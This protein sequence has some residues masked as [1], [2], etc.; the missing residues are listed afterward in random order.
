MT[1]KIL[2]MILAIV[3]VVSLFAGITLTASAAESV[4][5]S[6]IDGD[7][8]NQ[9]TWTFTDE[10]SGV[11]AVFATGTGSTKPRLDAN[12]IRFY[13]NNT[14]TVTAPAGSSITAI[15]FTMS[16]TSYNLSK[17][18]ADSG[19]I[20]STTHTWTGS[21]G[22]VVIT[23][24]AQVRMTG[25][26]VTYGSSGCAHTNVVEAAAVDP[27]CTT[28]GSTA[29]T[30]CADCGAIVTGC[31]VIAALGHSYSDVTT[32]PT[33][34][35]AGL[36]TSTC[37]VCG[38][39]QTTTI[40]ATGLHNFVDGFC[41]V[42]GAEDLDFSGTY[43]IAAIRSSGNYMY[44]SNDLGTASTLR[45]QA[46]DSTLT[47]LPEAITEANSAYTFVITRGED[48]TYTIT[49]A[50]GKYVS[51]T[52]GN[53][54][55]LADDP[56]YVN[57]AASATEGLVNISLVADSTRILALNNT[58]TNNY[59]AFYAGTQVKDL[60]LVP[61]E[62]EVHTHEYTAVTTPA[63]CTEAGSVVYTC[64]CGDSYTE[65]IDMLPHDYVDGEC[66]EC[67][68]L[69]ETYVL[70]NA[71]VDGDKVIIYN[72]ASGMAMNKTSTATNGY[73]RTGTA[74]TPENDTIAGP[75]AA[76]V[77]TV[78]ADA[79][80]G[81]NLINADG[82]K[83]S[84]QIKDDGTGY[85]SIPYDQTGDA[86]VVVAA[87]T[88]KCVYINNNVVT[89]QLYY[90][91]SYANFSAHNPLNYTEAE[92]AM[93]IF[94]LN[95]A[96]ITCVHEWDEG[97]V[98]TEPTCTVDGVLTYTCTLCGET[99]TEAIAATGHT[100][101]VGTINGDSMSTLTCSVCQEETAPVY[102][103]NKVDTIANGDV[104]SIGMLYGG[105]TTTASGA[106]LAYAYGYKD[107]YT[108][109]S[110]A[111]MAV[112]EKAAALTVGYDEATGYYTFSYND[113]TTD[114]YLTA[115]ATGNGLSFAAEDTATNLQKW[116][117]E[118]YEGY[119]YIK[120]AEAAYNSN[121]QYI[122]QYYGF[123]TY[124]LG[125][126]GTAYQMNFYTLAPSN[127]PECAT[128]HANTTVEGAVE[129]TCSSTGYTGDTVCS[130][131]G[132]VVTY[133]TEIPTGDHSNGEGVV[134]T[135][136]TCV[137]EGVM[138]YTCTICGTVTTEAI[139]AT[140]EHNYVD[141]TC[142][143]CGAIDTTNKD[144]SGR[145]YIAAVRTA[146]GSTYQ[147]MTDDLGTASTK[148][149]QAVDS[150][151][152]ELPAEITS[153]TQECVF[154][155][156]KNED[157][158]YTIQNIT[159][160]YLSWTSGN[161]G[162]FSEE[163]LN[164]TVTPLASGLF[165][166]TFVVSE[167][168]TRYL[169]LNSN[170][171]SNYFAFY[172]PTQ[173]YDLALVPVAE[174]A[175]I[176]YHQY[177][178][179]VTE[180]YVAPTCTEPGSQTFKCSCGKTM[181]EEIPATGHSEV[182][183]DNVDGTHSSQCSVCLE[184]LS[185]PVG[186]TYVD[187][188]CEC[189]AL[190]PV[191]NMTVYAINSS[192]WNEVY[193]Y[194]WNSVGSYEVA[195]PGAAMTKTEDTVNG[196]DVYSYTYPATND[197]L[198][199]NNNNNGSQTGDLIGM[200][201]KYYDIKSDTWYDSLA[202][203]PAIDPQ[204]TGVYMAGEFNEWSTL[205]NE[206]KKVEATDTVATL[207]LELA[208]DTSYQFKIVNNSIWT[209][210]VE[211]IT[212]TVSG[213]SFSAANNT[214][215]TLTT[216]AAGIYTFTYDLVNNTL[217]VVYPEVIP[218]EPTEVE[219]KISH[220]VSF[221]SDLKMNYRIKYTDIAAAVPNYTMDGAYLT[222]EK[223]RYPMGGGAKTVETVSLEPDLVSDDKRVLFSL[224]GIQSVE[225]GSELRAV[226]HFFDTDGN[227]YYTT[228]DAY[229]VLAYA[230]LCFD[231][232]DPTV[233][234]YLFTMLIDCLNY[235]SAAQVAFDRRA[236]ELVNAG[237]DAYQQYAT[238]ELSAELTD[239]RT[240]VENDRS[241]TAVTK[242]GFTVV[243]ADKTEINAKM[244]IADGYTKTDI[245]SVKV[246]NE[247]GEEVAVLTEFTELDDGRL[248]VTFT[249]MKSVDMRNMYYFVAYVGDQ[250]ASQ[251]VGYSIEAYAKSNI[252]SS[253]ASAANLARACIYYGDS[254]KV[255]FDSLMG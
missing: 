227:E 238:T 247:A 46:V 86:W 161:S 23:A 156:T 70:T 206:F 67:G 98:T 121:A 230:Q 199:F 114:L 37:S 135:E 93:Q 38:D 90:G 209:S 138:T 196:F 29:G 242:M 194:V 18:T 42:C 3:M 208:A 91:T 204:A 157:G 248:Q 28:A 159:G 22:T 203:V 225:M 234:A 26:V 173:I 236:D 202:D 68:A 201:G 211:A 215:A 226:L 167:T 183:V 130:D 250:V 82:Q 34:G 62:G 100:Y 64:S 48:R 170:S 9:D 174:N 254:A 14:L 15:V 24:G 50:N 221:D 58:S 249:G 25:A 233:D 134:T 146:E 81:F 60:A 49:D 118:A 241:I 123:T 4:T 237:L 213:I 16:S 32:E 2:S 122:E 106:K 217:S 218:A 189:G 214:N 220:T 126:G 229:S 244:T 21:A 30:K 120:N 44:M 77:W 172:K 223:D 148:R 88:A 150:T 12:L 31:E 89:K 59:F 87:A 193:A 110:G 133:G 57:I 55:A 142:S 179:E 115:P 41:D 112:E 239:V 103:Y 1:K 187:G 73:Y 13:T 175:E 222:V 169:S 47:A 105:L 188:A 83:L 190:E 56:A 147:Y 228:V 6:F 66:A 212:G 116:V 45:F 184:V 43:Y 178:E 231:F 117:L 219:V 163:A 52:S 33:C 129:A 17:A 252:A 7:G 253:D 51:W 5:L 74:V 65:T 151:L 40:P 191:Q 235:G 165:N 177:T 140:G 125:S 80:G 92:H 61:V 75:D 132:L 36:T 108:A 180:A 155:L 210:C 8:S 154:T 119:Y 164:L 245:T 160:E 69:I 94:V 181:T 145:Y 63:T 141:G 143:V 149:Y 127:A 255:Y 186:H 35:T 10:T 205:T 99:T 95:G 131:C 158:T 246:L 109:T 104:V 76:I 168:E 198:I 192:N 20:D 176:H 11:S 53:S 128:G 182:L 195:W 19:T 197:M 232:Y 136:P 207:T 97:T 85:N 251:N 153:A 216:A 243:F 113:G 171:S 185:E 107:L 139:A 39:V 54:G 102:V 101:T 200:D 152:T 72:P 96:G 240:Y 27:T 71:I 78:A 224:S 162:T 84:I 137:A 79:E 166:I 124:G 144:Y 111:T